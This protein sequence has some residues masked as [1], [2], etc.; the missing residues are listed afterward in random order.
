MGKDLAV[1][2]KAYHDYFILEEIEA[3]LA[4]TGTEIKSL[5][6]GKAQL[7]DSYVSFRNGEAFVK[8]MNIS[9]YDHGNRNNHEEDRDRKLLLHK[10]EIVKLM[11][12]V[13]TQGLT[14]IPLKLYLKAG[15]AK[16]LIALTKGKT[17]YDKRESDKIRTMNEAAHKAMRY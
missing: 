8:G 7:K 4:L 11:S 14:V 3:G 9:S 15:W 2:K 13:K 1:N 10:R 12:K 16:C 6:K 5:R 17:L